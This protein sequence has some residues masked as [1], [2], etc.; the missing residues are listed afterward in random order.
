MVKL[1]YLSSHPL[2]AMNSDEDEEEYAKIAP[3]TI[4]FHHKVSNNYYANIIPQD[5]AFW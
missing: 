1:L 4:V 5:I 3:F 2:K